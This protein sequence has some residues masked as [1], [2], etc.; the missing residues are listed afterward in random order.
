[1][2]TQ[3][4]KR[5]WGVA[6]ALGDVRRGGACDEMQPLE[7]IAGPV[8]VA[9]AAWLGTTRLIDNILCRVPSGSAGPFA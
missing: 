7:R 5:A 3:D 1:M 6:K 9:A 2:M 8:R 4:A